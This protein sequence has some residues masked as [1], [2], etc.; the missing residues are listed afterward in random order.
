MAS[1]T[2]Y[3]D[4][5]GVKVT[6]AGGAITGVAIGSEQKL[7]V[8]GVG[9]PANANASVNDPTQVE[10]RLDADRKFGDGSELADALKDAI[11][12]GANTDFLYG[13]LLDETAVTTETFTASSSGTLANAPILEDLSTITVR[14]TVDAVDATVEFRYSSPP[15]APSNADTVFINPITAEWTADSSSDYEFDYSYPDWT[16]GIDAAN[17]NVA[18]E[19]TAV[20]SLLSES[21]SIASE[22]SGD[23][24][25]IREDYKLAVGLQAAEPNANT[26]DNDASY[27]T[28]AYSDGID[29][30]SLFLHAPARKQD[31]SYTITGAIG[32]VMAGNDLNESI[33]YSELDVADLEQRLTETQK[34]D[35]RDEEVIPVAQP[36]QG[37]AV[38]VVDNLST[39]TS[40]DWQ[41]DYWRK[42]IVDQTVL[43]A[44]S[45]GDS[46]LGRINDER[47]R[48]TVENQIR[49]ELRGLADDRLIEEGEDEGWFVDVYE[50]DA[51]TVGIDL[52]V[53]PNG[54]AK[55][56]DT[57]ITVNT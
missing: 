5:P 33:Y 19:E 45:V 35:L 4:F 11:A 8:V 15:A 55:R 56:I 20:I 46:V 57:T 14:D 52:G 44:K 22:L 39:S 30:D 36:E 23:I 37:G 26:S 13:V 2:T 29:N 38:R 3:G 51:D 47:T 16:S 18:T 53:T 27:D 17:A 32:G 49:V 43:I 25:T 6:T 24:N 7:L 50:V 21:E 34:D 48:D 28:A 31:S 12:N 54:L 1:T 9:D 41:R 42:R 10:T 40:T